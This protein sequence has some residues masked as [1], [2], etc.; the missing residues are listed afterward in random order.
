MSE[1]HALRLNP[2]TPVRVVFN[3]GRSAMMF[4]NLAEARERFPD[5]NPFEAG[6]RFGWA[7]LGKVDGLPA[8]RFES[9]D[10]YRL[11]GP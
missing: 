2:A 7:I 9:H 10:T 3:K 8:L 11:M 6:S 1:L 5:L 4:V